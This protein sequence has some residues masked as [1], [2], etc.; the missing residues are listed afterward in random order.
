MPPVWMDRRG[1]HRAG[2][3]PRDVNLGEEVTSGYWPPPPGP[4][5]T[6]DHHGDVLRSA[7]LKPGQPTPDFYC[8]RSSCMPFSHSYRATAWTDSYHLSIGVF[9]LR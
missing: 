5:G 4:P 7:R 8:S 9:Y 3:S 1:P 6:G 2:Q